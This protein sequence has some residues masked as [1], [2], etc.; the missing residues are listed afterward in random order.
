M[1]LPAH[2]FLLTRALGIPLCATRGDPLILAVSHS[3]FAQNWFYGIFIGIVTEQS[4]VIHYLEMDYL[5]QMLTT[6]EH[7]EDKDLHDSDHSNVTSY[8]HGRF[9]IILLSR[10]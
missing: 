9:Y 5:S 4:A 2:N 10:V 3:H 7:D 1:C 8:V 6:E